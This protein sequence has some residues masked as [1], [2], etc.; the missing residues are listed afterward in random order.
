M[1]TMENLLVKVSKQ[2]E[3][4]EGKLSRQTLAMEA[5]I[6][7]QT[8]EQ[9]AEGE[10]FEI[11]QGYGTST[12]KT[13]ILSDTETV[14][15]RENGQIL[16]VPK[17]I[18]YDVEECTYEKCTSLKRALSFRNNGQG[19]YKRKDTRQ[20]NGLPSRVNLPDTIRP[21]LNSNEPGSKDRVKQLAAFYQSLP[22]DS[23][24]SAFN[25]TSEDIENYMVMIC[26]EKDKTTKLL[27]QN[28]RR[29]SE[30]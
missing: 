25:V 7:R 27:F 5:S 10:V 16:T 22:A 30:D 23:E 3:Q 9:L 18:G 20:Q 12:Q 11:V 24:D 28:N 26:M 29:E 8:V 14:K 13:P 15:I 6:A 17:V 2:V 21:E 1:T 19:Y 4:L